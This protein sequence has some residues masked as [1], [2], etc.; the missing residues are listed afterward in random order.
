METL[1][2]IDKFA[3]LWINQWVGRNPAIDSVVILLVSDYFVPV[4]TSLALFAL[5]LSGQNQ[6]ALE[7]NQR[8]VL[9]AILSVLITALTIA[10]MNTVFDRPRPFEEL[11]VSLLF[12][13]PTDSSFPANP[14][15]IVTAMSSS[16]CIRTPRLGVPLLAL[17]LVFALSRVYAGVFY[18]FDVLG[19]AA[20]GFISA[21]V[22]Y[23]IAKFSEPA[24]AI[25]LHRLRV[26][27]LA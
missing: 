19:G 6:L 18:P 13:R 20:I 7:T 3:F 17:M 26:L 25:L 23:T 21:S 14:V 27:Y 9:I 10:L 12:Y 15:A 2:E 11:N 8:T 22:S 24:M 4:V 5:W 1:T 16:V